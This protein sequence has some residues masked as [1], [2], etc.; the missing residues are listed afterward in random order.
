MYLLNYRFVWIF[1]AKEWDSESYDYNS[2]FLV[3]KEM[4]SVLHTGC[5]NLFSPVCFLLIPVCLGPQTSVC[6]EIT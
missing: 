5:T 4:P 6:T 2:Y 3:L 1:D